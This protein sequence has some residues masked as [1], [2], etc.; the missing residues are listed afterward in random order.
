MDNIN[1]TFEELPEMK[2]VGIAEFGNPMEGMNI[3]E[4]W[5]R[6]IKVA[7]EIKN[8]IDSDDCY[9]VETYP[10]GFP[11]PFKFTYFAGYKVSDLDV[12]PIRTV[13]KTLPKSLYAIFKV[14]G[15]TDKIAGTFKKVY[16]EWLP[17]SGY[18]LAYPF[19]L[20]LY[21][22]VEGKTPCDLDI[23]VCL[24]VIKL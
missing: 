7:G 2:L 12:I 22:H 20:E 17:T 18:R 1:P 24:P 3:G 10:P 16:G 4:L 11:N 14:E 23:F 5:D 9:G 21:R 13:A 15:G 8:R 19:D 6:F